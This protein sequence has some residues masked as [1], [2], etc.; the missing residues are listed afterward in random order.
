L[1]AGFGSKLFDRT[2][3]GFFPTQ[4]GEDLLESAE[5]V[6]DELFKAQRD[7]AGRDANLSAEARLRASLPE[8]SR[9]YQPPPPPR[10]S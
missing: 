2:R 7:I 5:R 10:M 1:E 6:G 4:A 3:D 8:R 9:R